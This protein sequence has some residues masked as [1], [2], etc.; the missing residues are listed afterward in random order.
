VTDV[1]ADAGALDAQMLCQAIAAGRLRYTTEAQLQQALADLFADAGIDADGQVRLGVHERPDFMAGGVAVELKV[2][3]TL[4]DLTR[5]LGRYAAH[6]QVT[7]VIVVT[8]CARHRDV[9]REINGKPVYVV[10]LSG[11]TG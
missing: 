2:K 9:P 10:W 8:R 6:D 5:Q 11:L 1:T 7:A 4:G 3:G